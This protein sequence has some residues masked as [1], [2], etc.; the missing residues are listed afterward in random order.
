MGT[1]SHLKS[2]QALEM[3]VREG[4]LKAAAEKLGITPAAVGQRIRSLEDYLGSDLLVRGRSGLQPTRVLDQALEDLRIAFEALERAT[5]TFDFQRVSEI[6]IV[7]DPDWSDLWLLPR[8]SE[9]RD[10]NPAVL[11]CIN[12]TGDVP[13]RLGSPDIRIA[14]DITDG[15]PLYHDIMVPITGLDN[16]RRVAG[17][18]PVLQMEGMPL[19]HLK[20]QLERDG[21]PGWV[22]WFEKY[23]Q[24]EVG[25]DR[26]VS[27]PN[28]RLALEAVK[29]DVGFLVCNLS[30]VLLD[31]EQERI[32]HP[33]PLSMHIA[34]PRPYR[35]NLG[36]DARKR[37]PILRF[38]EWLKSKSLETQAAIDALKTQPHDQA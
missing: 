8:L 28:A 12:G 26:G 6:H 32:V 29:Q 20:R 34:S 27:Y 4:S 33:F 1:P 7:A 21:D 3:A 31:L 10:A 23:G 19:L 17:F 2:M 30:L 11:F 5:D 22:D 35:V 16:T 13:V 24:R 15:E 37:A 18:D 36:N 9:F 14:M 25:R 38:A